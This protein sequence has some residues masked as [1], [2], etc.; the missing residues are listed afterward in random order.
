[1]G[2]APFVLVWETERRNK[3]IPSLEVVHYLTDGLVGSIGNIAF[4]PSRRYLAVNC[5]NETH[6][7]VIYDLNKLNEAKKDITSSENGVVVS[8]KGTS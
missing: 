4:S 6:N 8:D 3:D 1:M 5:D 2:N 7:I